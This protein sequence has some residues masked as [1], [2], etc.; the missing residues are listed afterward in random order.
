MKIEE[1]FAEELVNRLE[2]TLPS[3]ACSRS[4]LRCVRYH[5]VRGRPEAALAVVRLLAETQPTPPRDWGPPSK[6]WGF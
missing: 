1:E 5:L 4:G 6:A 3:D 2:Q